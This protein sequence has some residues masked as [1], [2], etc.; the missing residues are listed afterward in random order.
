VEGAYPTF[1]HYNRLLKG[2]DFAAWEQSQVF[3]EEVR[4]AFMSLR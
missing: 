1:I 2:G 3:S 4:T